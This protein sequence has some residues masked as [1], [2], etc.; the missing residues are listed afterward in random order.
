MVC[1]SRTFTNFDHLKKVL[2]ELISRETDLEGL[3]SG[4]AVGADSLAEQYAAAYDI[5]IEVLKPEWDRYGKR[6]GFIR[7]AQMV[8]MLDKNGLVVAFWDGKSN[9]TRHSIDY[10][11]SKQFR[12]HIELFTPSKPKLPDVNY[13]S[14]FR[15]A[16]PTDNPN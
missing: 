11:N 10:A 2:D 8:D 12:V 16:T 15:R 14:F 9:G 3:I 4:G 5:P 1:G 7:N 6:A 13:K